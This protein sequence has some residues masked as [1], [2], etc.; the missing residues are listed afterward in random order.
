M[1]RPDENPEHNPFTMAVK[2]H[3]C[4]YKG[5]SLWEKTATGRVPLS[6]DDFYARLTSKKLHLSKI[7]T[8]CASCNRPQ[9]V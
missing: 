6:L 3:W 1:G 2:C 4:G 8:V 5:L 7:E 9:P